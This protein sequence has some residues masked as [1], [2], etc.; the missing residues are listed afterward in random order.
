MNLPQ[1]TGGDSSAEA[2]G[3]SG[4]IGAEGEQSVSVNQQSLIDYLQ[5]GKTINGDVMP[6]YWTDSTRA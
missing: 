3:F 5:N 1:H 2:V 4:Q 6:T